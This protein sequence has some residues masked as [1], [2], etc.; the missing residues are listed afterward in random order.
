MMKKIKFLIILVF[1]I[2]ISACYLLLISDTSNLNEHE[3]SDTDFDN[4]P[5]QQVDKQENSNS[6]KLSELINA[7]IYEH[8]IEDKISVYIHGFSNNDSYAHNANAN[9]FAASI[10]KV[11]LAMLYYEKINNGELSFENTLLYENYHYE[12]GGPIGDYYSFG[13]YIPIETLLE[14][15]IVYSD[16]TA[17]HILFENLGGWVSFKHEITKYSKSGID[18][19]FYSTENILTANYMNDVMD[20]LYVNRDKFEL[21]LT[22]MKQQTSFN[23]LSRYVEADIAQK[24]GLYNDFVNSVGL[25]FGSSPY[26]IVV[27]TSLGEQGVEHIARINEICYNLYNK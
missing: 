27:F 23:F 3:I 16:N 19:E 22:D 24:Y 8:N 17:A 6:V 2:S 5:V 10:Y 1:L 14:Y 18:N 20:Y 15:M 13:S 25:V 7:Y 11:P 9:F 12:S 21:L 26:S 4:A